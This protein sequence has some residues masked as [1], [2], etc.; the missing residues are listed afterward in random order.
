MTTTEYADSFT[1]AEGLKALPAGLRQALAPEL[2]ALGNST[3]YFREWIDGQHHLRKITEAETLNGN[4]VTTTIN[5]TGIN[6]PV[7]ITLPPASQTFLFQGSGPVSGN[8]FNGD[9]GAKAVPAPPGFAL[10]QDPN[11]HSGPPLEYPW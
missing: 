10:S 11:E 7:H 3:I 8:S 2:Q 4:T 5:I 9:L 6:Q 1:A